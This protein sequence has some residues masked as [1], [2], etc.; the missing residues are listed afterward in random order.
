MHHE[1]DENVPALD[2]LLRQLDLEEETETFAHISPGPP[3]DLKKHNLDI[4]LEPPEA[5]PGL[6]EL[7]L[8][9]D[10]E[11]DFTKP[12]EPPE[13]LAQAASRL[14]AP[15]LKPRTDP[16]AKASAARP[17]FAE[18]RNRSEEQHSEPGP[19]AACDV[20]RENGH[21]ALMGSLG[22]EPS[23][24]DWSQLAAAVRN[25][26]P[27]ATALRP[28]VEVCSGVSSAVPALA[29]VDDDDDDDS[30]PKR[31]SAFAWKKRGPPAQAKP[32]RSGAALGQRAE[33]ASVE[34]EPDKSW[35]PSSASTARR[36]LS[37]A[38]ESAVPKA[39]AGTI[40]V[41]TRAPRAQE[42]GPVKPKVEKR[43]PSSREITQEDIQKELVQR[44]MNGH[45][46][47]MLQQVNAAEPPTSK[48]HSLVDILLGRKQPPAP[49]PAFV[50]KE[51]E[52]RHA[53][54]EAKAF[55][56]SLKAAKAKEE[57]EQ[58][59]LRRRRAEAAAEERERQ[60][61]AAEEAVERQRRASQL[62]R[63]REEETRQRAAAEAAKRKWQRGRE[64]EERRL[65][66][67]R[68]VEEIKQWR[69]ER[70][71]EREER[72]ER[73]F[74]ERMDKLAE[75]LARYRGR[76]L[77]VEEVLDRRAAQKR[78]GG[79][80]DGEDFDEE[81]EE[82]EEGEWDCESIWADSHEEWQQ[83]EEEAR[84]EALA[85]DEEKDPEPAKAMLL[86]GIPKPLIIEEAEIDI[87]EAQ[88][89]EPVLNP[90][91]VETVE[92]PPIDEILESIDRSE[93]QCWE[94]S[95]GVP[96]LES[97]LAVV[98]ADARR[99]EQQRR[100]A[101]VRQ[102]F[103][104]L[105]RTSHDVE[106]AETDPQ[107]AIVIQLAREHRPDV[108]WKQIVS[109]ESSLKPWNYLDE[110]KQ[111]N[112]ESLE[113]RQA[114]SAAIRAKLEKARN[115]LSVVRWSPEGAQ[116]RIL[117]PPRG[118]AS[119]GPRVFK[120]DHVQPDAASGTAEWPWS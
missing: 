23:Q 17:N 27:A 30:L 98:D 56:A 115:R 109:T 73:R 9:L 41:S 26:V 57:A 87:P 34:V 100:A 79:Q 116:P 42:Q 6:E 66:R 48:S 37:A 108:D 81:G 92:V 14:P 11:E 38:A 63:I 25:W 61:M 10:T 103:I 19:T 28:T 59:E 99:D 62:S 33:R 46:G 51:A 64:A 18:C 82:E 93:K 114:R 50:G 21:T 72:A 85:P 31:R 80:S 53:E 97:V 52:K 3:E 71:R 110:D 105:S 2:D 7:L 68:E 15:Q 106:E 90:P 58:R 102:R 77:P 112:A 43:A 12:E 49:V 95:N 83:D 74:K 101:A 1:M 94:G 39:T 84:V 65:E 24:G 104:D 29:G 20:T 86:D 45:V 107:E 22:S 36:P 5:I 91:K 60:C 70:R 89:N 35:A 4:T 40:P 8:E 32:P 16:D 67:E 117:G 47:K 78:L 55:E 75:G 76:W 96:L 54:A 88:E 119:A 120:S 118:S 69:E 113:E 111:E 44:K 13:Q